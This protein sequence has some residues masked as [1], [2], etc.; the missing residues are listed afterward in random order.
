MLHEVLTC[1]FLILIV[2][3]EV[4]L[5]SALEISAALAVALESSA[6]SAETLSAEV[7]AAL[8]VAF[9]STASALVVIIASA[10]VADARS[11]STANFLA[12]LLEV[13]ESVGME[14]E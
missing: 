7:L 10:A 9:E 1:S 6:L 3:G 2:I 13:L 8:T 5:S 14:L 4:T 12:A 11:S